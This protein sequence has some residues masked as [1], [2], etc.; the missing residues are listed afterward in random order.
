MTGDA[1]QKSSFGSV[2]D[3]AGEKTE[4][5][6]PSMSSTNGFRYPLHNSFYA[7]Y[8]LTITRY[9]GRPFDHNVHGWEHSLHA[10]VGREL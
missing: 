7:F 5:Y 2:L 3:V 10:G 8:E 6:L 9:D 1:T 4:V